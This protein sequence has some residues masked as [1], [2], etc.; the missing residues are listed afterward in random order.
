MSISFRPALWLTGAAAAWGVA[1]VISKRAVEEI[2]PFV[3]L[4]MQLTISVLVLLTLAGLLRQRV[5]WSAGMRRLAVLGVLNPGISYALSLLGLVHITA[6]MSV[7][8]WAIEPLLILLLARLVLHDCIT[9]PVA[10]AM[11]AATA[12]VLLVVAQPGVG[13]SLIGVA[14]TLAGVGA[15]AAYTVACRKLLADDAALTVVLAQ[16]SCA[17]VFAIA[18][19]VVTYIVRPVPALGTVSGWAWASAMTSGALYYALAFGLYL[20]GLRR[21]AAST[22]GT[23]LTLIPVFGVAAAYLLLGEHLGGRQWFGAVLVV[24][25]VAALTMVHRRTSTPV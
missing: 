6:S 10:T 21:V 16:Q 12:G 8:L 18:G 5:V 20:A 14:L 1:T 13:G 7:L 2:P 15:C 25:A 3:L 11:L 4:A 19:C 24:G 17:L 23:F 9:R 22:A